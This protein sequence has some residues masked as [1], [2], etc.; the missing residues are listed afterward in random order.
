[1]ELR[2][3]STR[4]GIKFIAVNRNE[5]AIGI[6]NVLG[7]N[8]V[9]LLT[10]WFDQADIIHVSTCFYHKQPLLVKGKV[11][12]CCKLCLNSFPQLSSGNKV[13]RKEKVESTRWQI[14]SLVTCVP[15]TLQANQAFTSTGKPTV[16]TRSTI[17]HSATN[18]L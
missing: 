7:K 4:V 1:M 16:E 6:L 8:N 2:I 5:F 11:T 13:S 12:K 14:E 9:N 10:N 17:V 3:M 18:H 15:R